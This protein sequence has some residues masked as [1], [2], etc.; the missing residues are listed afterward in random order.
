MEQVT[1]WRSHGGNQGV[2]LG[3]DK[4]AWREHDAC[5][6]IADGARLPN[7]LVDQDEADDF[8]VDQLRTH[9]LAEVCEKVGQSEN[10]RMQAGY[11]HSCYSVSTF[12]AEHIAWH[13]AT[14]QI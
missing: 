5:A 1:M 8:L 9:L 4:V 11:D 3:P 14:L 2:Y 7:L 12:L 13:A 10:I 6:L